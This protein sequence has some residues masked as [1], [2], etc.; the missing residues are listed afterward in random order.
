M[1]EPDY[2]KG[3]KPTSETVQNPDAG[4]SAEQKKE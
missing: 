3:E 2:Y 1:K 4:Q